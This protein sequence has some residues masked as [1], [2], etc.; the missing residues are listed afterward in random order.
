MLTHVRLFGSPWAAACQAPL[1]MGFYRQEYWSLFSF[2]PLGDFPNPGIKAPSPASP[3]LQAHF[4]FFFFY[5]G[6]TRYFKQ[7]AKTDFE[8]I[9]VNVLTQF[10]SE[11]YFSLYWP[12]DNMCLHHW[13]SFYK[14]EWLTSDQ[15]NWFG[16]YAHK[17]SAVYL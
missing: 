11:F 4:F 6:V 14:L 13:Y 12:N 16:N 17:P 7:F 1:S 2:P 8:H 3:A 5:H 10:K 9:C 15:K